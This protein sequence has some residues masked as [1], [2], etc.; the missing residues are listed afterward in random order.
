MLSKTLI[1][2]L[3]YWEEKETHILTFN[4]SGLLL[5][6]IFSWYQHFIPTET[7]D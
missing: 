6:Q 3:L 5:D 2:V 4:T 1:N 7:D